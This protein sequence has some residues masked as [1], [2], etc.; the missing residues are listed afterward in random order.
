MVGNLWH[1]C[2]GATHPVLL[3]LDVPHQP[4]P[5]ELQGGISL[6]AAKERALCPAG[7]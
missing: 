4:L 1:A 3:A 5:L 2:H 7:T 6:D